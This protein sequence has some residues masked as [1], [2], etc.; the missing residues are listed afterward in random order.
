MASFAAFVL[1][2]PRRAAVAARMPTSTACLLAAALVAAPCLAGDGLLSV[3]PTGTPSFAVNVP[4]GGSAVLRVV[5]D[6]VTPDADLSC[7]ANLFRLTF[8]RPGIEVTGYEWV[9]PWVTGGPTDQSL[10]GLV[11]PVAVY[12]ETLQGPGY[13][14]A[15]NDV[16]FGNFL[17]TGDAQPGEYARVT[18]RV[19][20]GTPQGTSFYVIAAPDQ[21]TDGFVSLDVESGDVL[22]VRVVSGSGTPTTGDL[23]ADGLVNGADLALMLGRW[24]TPDAVADIDRDGTVGGTDLGLLL[25]NWSA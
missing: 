18:I 5:L 7:N 12:P 11:L 22:E 13:P 8:T 16:E 24:S 10:A 23:N 25:A 3:R 19:P 9:S 17:M 4:P 20:A 1:T 15:T 6:R 14:I 2:C 21:F